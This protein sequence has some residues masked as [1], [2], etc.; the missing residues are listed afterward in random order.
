MTIV[1]FTVMP[2][3]K[4]LLAAVVA[5]AFSAA[6]FAASPGDE[7]PFREGA[8]MPPAPSGMSWCL[9]Q[10]PAVYDYVSDTVVVRPKSTFQVPVPGEYADRTRSVQTSPAHR[11]GNVIPAK[12]D[13]RTMTY[14]SQE[15][16]EA[17]EVIPP[18]F[19]DVWE[20]IEICPA[21]EQL[22]VVP[23][24]FRD[25]S[26][27]LKTAPARKTF[28]RIGCGDDSMCWKA[29]DTAEQ[30][31]DVPTRVLVADAREER[32][33]VPAKR[34]RVLVRKLSK[35]AQIRRVNVPAATTPY[36]AGVVAAPPRVEWRTVPAEMRNVTIQVETKAPAFASQS[37]PEKTETI[38]RRVLVTPEQLVWRL[39]AESYSVANSCYETKTICPVAQ[40]VPVGTPHVCGW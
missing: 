35:P 24:K 4:L 39:G 23:A 16:Y 34:Q 6:A 29:L 7:V 26:E 40:C 30:Y 8:A 11:V 15:S 32:T 28:E 21:Y 1:R 31:I 33:T 12:L 38:S 2:G 19:V 17:L 22:S 25:S 3:K 9:V 14:V 13:S 18:E 36:Q 27:R 5:I 10:K 37:L 20:E